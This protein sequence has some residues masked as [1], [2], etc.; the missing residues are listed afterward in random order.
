[1]EYPP[2]YYDLLAEHTTELDIWE[3]EYHHVMESSDAI[4][5]WMSST[6]L[7]PFLAV[8]ADESERQRFVSLLR[9]GLPTPTGLSKTGKF[10]FLSVARS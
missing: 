10:C 1:M 5:D 4:I 6:G 7:R 9:A 3:T 2:V 8:L